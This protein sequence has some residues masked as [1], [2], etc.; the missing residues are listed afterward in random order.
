MI[1]LILLTASDCHLCAHGE[2]VLD[3]LAADGLVR[4]REV[5][6]DSDEGRALAAAAPPV[7]PV[8]LEAE[9]RVV[10]YGRLSARRLRR[11]LAA[12]LMP[13]RR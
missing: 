1:D 6:A 11:Q 5:G 9:G 10:A 4:W 3:E 7:R 8:L 2:H 12:P 13:G